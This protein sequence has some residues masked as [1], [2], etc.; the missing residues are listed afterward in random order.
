MKN[1]AEQQN[2]NQMA[3]T[4]NPLLNNIEEQTLLEKN[5]MNKNII[6]KAIFMPNVFFI[7][8]PPIF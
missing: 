1:K 8:S 6:Q 3:N 2:N 5:K 7:F 4:Y